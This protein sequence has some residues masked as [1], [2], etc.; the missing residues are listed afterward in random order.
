MVRNSQLAAAQSLEQRHLITHWGARLSTYLQYALGQRDQAMGRATK[1]YLAAARKVC[2]GWRQHHAHAVFTAKEKI[3]MGHAAVAHHCATHTLFSAYHARTMR[4]HRHA[5]MAAICSHA[6][7]L[8]GR[9]WQQIFDA[10]QKE[11]RRI[12]R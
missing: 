3:F 11:R 7:F 6:T 8:L 9:H 5:S 1:M 12:Q 4:A 10:Y 2:Q